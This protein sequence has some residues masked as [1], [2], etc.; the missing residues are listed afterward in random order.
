MQGK[1]I[2]VILGTSIDG[3]IFGNDAVSDANHG[4][5]TDRTDDGWNHGISIFRSDR[6]EILGGDLGN[7]IGYQGRNEMATAVE[8][9]INQGLLVV[10]SDDFFFG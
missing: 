5:L 8:T 4:G 6:V 2:A 1:V 3:D 7:Q 9:F 10:R